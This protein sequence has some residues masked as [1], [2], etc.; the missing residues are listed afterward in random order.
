MTSREELSEVRLEPRSGSFRRDAFR[1]CLQ[2]DG[3]QHSLYHSL[4][5]TLYPLD[6]LSLQ[7]Y[8][9]FSPYT[10]LVSVAI[11]CPCIYNG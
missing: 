3:P 2:Q 10:L 1:I 8:E 5:L 6:A 4:S 11:H 7:E 9:C